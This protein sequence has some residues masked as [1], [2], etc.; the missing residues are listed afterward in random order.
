[1]K[2]RKWNDQDLILAVK[3][4]LSYAE[5]I[6]KLGLVPYGSNYDMLK[7][8]IKKL[9]LD[10][11]HMT[12]QG[13]NTGDR[14]KLPKTP[15]SLSEILV[16][17]SEYVNTNNLRQKLL[18]AGIKEYKC[19]CCNQTE[20]MG[21]PIPLELHHINGVKDDLRIENLQI[22]CP[23]CHAFTDNY[24]GKNQ[25]QSAQKE[26][27]NVESPKL[28]E[29]LTSNV[30]GNLEPSLRNQEGAE[31]R[32]GKSKFLIPKYCPVCGKELLVKSNKYCSQKCAHIAVSKRPSMSDLLEAFKKYKSYVQVGKYFNV[33][34]NGVRKWVKS[35]GIENMIKEQ[36]SAQTE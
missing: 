3:N 25:N 19:E 31:T 27:S 11:S 18:K 15:K 28:K 7:K 2:K 21:K 24:R 20:W 29:T 30:D 12:G 9:N 17:H 1:M 26:T 34:D 35:Y 5:A 6:R 13:W 32:R 8:Q 14:F 22:L 4:S 33:S 23:N 10:T 36:S 16:E